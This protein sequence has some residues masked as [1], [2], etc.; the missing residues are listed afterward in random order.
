M[1]RTIWRG[2]LLEAA[3]TPKIVR[4]RVQRGELRRATR[5]VYADGPLDADEQLRALFLRL[6]A[7]AVLARRSAAHRLGFEAM[8]PPTVQIMLPRGVARPRM[9]EVT[10]FEA[11]VPVGE[12]VVVRGVPCAPPARVAVDLA[13]TSRRLG[14]LPYLDAVL[15]AGL[16]THEALLVEVDRHHWLRGVRQARELIPLADGR[17]ECRQESQLRL[18]LIDGRLPRPEV[19]L[20]V[21]DA[22]GVPRFRLDLGYDGRKVGVEYDGASHL[23]RERMHHD[24]DR[25]NWLAGQGWTMRYFTDRDLYRRPQH[26]VDTLRAALRPATHR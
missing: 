18:V 16:A 21:C 10:V 5:G 12:P 22:L 20:W 23:E 19:Q 26:I 24:R 1:T 2:R 13:R 17:A 15:R 8:A 11:I 4:Q 7:E 9:P 6:P 25:A 3:S 14:A